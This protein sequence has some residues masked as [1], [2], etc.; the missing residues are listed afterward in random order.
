MQAYQE[1]P[2]HNADNSTCRQA[3]DPEAHQ[4]HQ[5][6][7]WNVSATGRFIEIYIEPLQLQITCTMVGA[8]GVYAVLVTYNLSE[9]QV[10]L[11]VFSRRNKLQLLVSKHR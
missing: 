9:Q 10:T 1:Q 4:V 5:D 8:G 2:W 11:R 3:A 6:G 7:A